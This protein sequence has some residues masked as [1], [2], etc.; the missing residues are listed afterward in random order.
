[1]SHLWFALGWAVVGGA[2][3][4]FVAPGVGTATPMTSS[5]RRRNDPVNGTANRNATVTAQMPS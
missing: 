2:L 4:S 3:G 1:M 5:D